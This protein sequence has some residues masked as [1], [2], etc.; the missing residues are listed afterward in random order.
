[1]ID[2]ALI[3]YLITSFGI[4]C[5]ILLQMY[6]VIMIILCFLFIYLF[7]LIDNNSVLMKW[8]CPFSVFSPII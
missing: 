2:F 6:W 5:H 7:V 3:F 1:M 4:T 8:L